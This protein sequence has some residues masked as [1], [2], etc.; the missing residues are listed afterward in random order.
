[1]RHTE[2]GRRVEV[3]QGLLFAIVASVAG[4]CVSA[5]APTQTS[6]MQSVGSPVSAQRVR[7]ADHNLARNFM[8]IVELTADSVASMTDDPD[9][10]YNTLVW[11]ANGIPAIQMALYH[12]EPL[13]AFADGWILLVQMRE[14][15]EN[16]GGKTAFGDYQPYVVQALRAGETEL[17]DTVEELG[18]DPEGQFQ[19]FVYGW[20][21]EH[22]ITNDRFLRR[23]PTEAVA[24]L[25]AAQPGGGL[26]SLGTL[27]EM[28]GDAQ[29]MA[30]VM[31]TY[32]PRQVTWQAELM[33]AELTDSASVTSL[34]RAIDDME[35][36]AAT[37]EFMRVT[38]E[39]IASERAAVFREIAEMRL[40]TFRDID[41]LRRQTMQDVAA[42][43]AAERSAAIRDVAALVAAERKALAEEVAGL[44]SQS[45]HEARGLINHLMIWVAALGL[46]LIVA[47]AVLL[48]LIRRRTA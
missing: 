38:P 42:T 26:S 46:A 35:V 27:T 4:G 47:V 45:F 7:V 1:M 8:A 24:D 15:F 13:V 9:I 20:A 36:M 34:L 23:S 28:A 14:Y 21:D 30:L 17:H 40:E 10:A 12:P 41:A 44:T 25:L 31:A 19:A 37:T 39:M 5:K 18:G 3:G 43:L 32:A 33:L 2:H 22:P 16:G 48:S 29:Q 11:K 6:F